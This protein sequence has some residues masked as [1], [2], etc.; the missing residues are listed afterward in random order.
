MKTL[1]SK[2]LLAGITSFLLL[3]GLLVFPAFADETDLSEKAEDVPVEPAEP[4]VVFYAEQMKD[5]MQGSS[6]FAKYSF[7]EAE[8][9]TFLNLEIAKAGNDPYVA[10]DLDGDYS[11]EVYKYVTVFAK[12]GT[13]TGSDFFSLF[14]ATEGTDNKFVGGSRVGT[15]YNVINGW[16]ALTFDMTKSEK[17]T[18]NLDKIRYDF[19]EGRGEYTED[20]NCQIYALVLSQTVEDIYNFSFD[21][22]CELYAPEQI[23]S[24]FTEEDLASIAKSPL[25]TEVSV[26]DGNWRLYAP[27]TAGDP[28]VMFDYQSLTKARGIKALTTDDFRYTVLRYRTSMNIMSPTMELFILTG[29]ADDLWDMS[30]VEGQPIC[31]AGSAKYQNSRTWRGVMVDFAEDDGLDEN[32]GLKYGWQGRGEFNGFR[33]DWCNSATV[34]SYIEISDMLM[35]ADKAAAKGFADALS[36]LTIPL[37]IVADEDETYETEHVVMPWETESETESE[38]ETETL[39]VFSEET[40]PVFTEDTEVVTIE[41]EETTVTEIETETDTKPVETEETEISEEESF[42]IITETDSVQGGD[43]EDF[44][45]IDI[46]GSDDEEQKDTGSQVPF[47]IACAALAGLSVASIVTVVIIRIKSK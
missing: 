14:F 47:Y 26:E 21:I 46:E 16:Q 18:G 33:F 35:F 32:T 45:G 28:S 19:F 24:D 17:W 13:L 22:F 39:P 8:G 27:E 36:S 6:Q 30:R 12:S 4:Y 43:V 38:T 2:K 44:P 15:K 9:K 20:N 25:K 40:L 7:Y 37:P 42:E 3:A 29:G 31:H 5:R 34:N 23:I 41:T 10:F 1:F 11:T